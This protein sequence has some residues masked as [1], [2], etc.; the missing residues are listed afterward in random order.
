MLRLPIPRRGGVGQPTELGGLDLQP[1][2]Q[3][4]LQPSLAR[5]RS[6]A[7]REHR[8]AEGDAHGRSHEGEAELRHGAATSPEVAE[9]AAAL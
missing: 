3:A 2:L 5:G 7:E 8:Q 6:S 4:R 1:G 9:R